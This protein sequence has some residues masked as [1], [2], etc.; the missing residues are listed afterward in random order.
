VIV[1]EDQWQGRQK[2]T[3]PTAQAELFHP[4]MPSSCPDGELQSS[5]FR[6]CSGHLGFDGYSDRKTLQREVLSRVDTKV[7]YRC[8]HCPRRLSLQE[9]AEHIPGRGIQRRPE[10]GHEDKIDQLA[11]DHPA[12][13]TG[14]QGGEE[15]RQNPG[16]GG[17]FKQNGGRALLPLR[18]ERETQQG[19]VDHGIPR[20]FAPA[21]GQTL[22]GHV[23]D[24]T[25]LVELGTGD[26]GLNR[27]ALG[28]HKKRQVVQVVSRKVLFRPLLWLLFRFPKRPRGGDGWRV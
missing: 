12:A 19:D 9:R 25:D 26:G 11:V 4:I 28:G 17:I 27:G 5:L 16:R 10:V 24:R 7:R 15:A 13:R 14:A 22:L 3:I 1:R 6:A 23:A 18:G 20:R 2:Q 8:R 21:E